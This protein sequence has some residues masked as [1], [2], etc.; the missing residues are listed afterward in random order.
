LLIHDLRAP[1]SVA[2]GYLRL[3]KDDHLG[4]AV[5][6]DRALNQTIDALTK[7]SQLCNDTSEYAAASATLPPAILTPFDSFLA[8]VRAACAASSPGGFPIDVEAD[9]AGDVSSR[10]IRVRDRARLVRALAIIFSAVRRAAGI[11]QVG[12]SVS[13]T[14]RSARFLMGT[15][16]A[17]RKLASPAP[18]AAFD[19][20]AGGH[21][22]ALPLACRAVAESDGGIG[23]LADIRAAV[24]VTLPLAECPA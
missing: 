3:L 20:W 16:D 12:V 10:S 4:S 15:L 19:P 13:M 5:V 6:R 9:Q 7:M 18:L 22:I 1:L 2:H 14:T 21:T 11:H 17:R 8:D 24:A 23:A